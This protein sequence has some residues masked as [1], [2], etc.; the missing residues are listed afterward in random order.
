MITVMEKTR[1][2]AKLRLTRI[3]ANR[4]PSRNGIERHWGSLSSFLSE[5]RDFQRDLRPLGRSSRSSTNLDI[6][7]RIGACGAFRDAGYEMGDQEIRL[8]GQKDEGRK[9]TKS[10]SRRIRI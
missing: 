1:M 8:S 4:T 5:V 7:Q 9:V 10:Q 2:D 6:G 3:D